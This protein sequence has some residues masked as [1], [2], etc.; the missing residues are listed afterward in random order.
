MESLLSS[1]I[2]P[3]IANGITVTLTCILLAFFDWRLALCVFITVPIAFLIIWPISSM[4]H[5]NYASGKEFEAGRYP[6][7][8]NRVEFEILA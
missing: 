2:P 6:F 3:L 8:G 4:G 5:F 1:T 7:V